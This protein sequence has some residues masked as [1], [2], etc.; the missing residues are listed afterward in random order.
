MASNPVVIRTDENKDEAT[1]KKES[2]DKKAY[3]GGPKIIISPWK[4]ERER[5]EVRLTSIK[6]RLGIA[7]KIQNCA[8]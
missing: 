1:V 5:I 3:I 4:S 2:A 7:E 6:R 8:N